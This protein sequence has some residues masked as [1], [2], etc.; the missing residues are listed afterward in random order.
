MAENAPTP[1]S[2]R[3]II[4]SKLSKGSELTQPPNNPLKGDETLQALVCW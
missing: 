4:A 3:C 1:S 2:I